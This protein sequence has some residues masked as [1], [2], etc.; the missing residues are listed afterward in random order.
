VLGTFILWFGWYS[1][2]CVSALLETLDDKAVAV[3]GLV[4]VNS[5]ITAGTA[6][7]VSLI[8]NS[9]LVDLNSPGEGVLDLQFALNG[10]LAGL[11]STTSCCAVIEP[12]AALVVGILAGFTYVTT[13][14]LVIRYRIDDAVDAIAVHMSCGMLGM[15][16]VGLFASPTRQ[17]N[18]YSRAYHTGL[19]YS[20]ARGEFD[21][22]L[23]GT[24][25]LGIGIVTCWVAAIML[26]FFV[27]FDRM[28]LLR[29]DAL[30]ELVGLDAVKHGDDIVESLPPLQSVQ[31]DNGGE[32]AIE[33]YKMRRQLRTE[34]ATARTSFSLSVPEST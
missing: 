4:S 33:S 27:C 9:W 11:V 14:R 13:N 6:A 20:F 30:E 34:L 23:L 7:I 2:N 12:W 29:C 21:C 19:V 1:F 32:D 24:Q 25:L 5:S 16:C 10:C 28:E 17:L 15:I 22:V 8:Y 3:A 31:K 18:A 26:P